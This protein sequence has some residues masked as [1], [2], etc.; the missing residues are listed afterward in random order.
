[1]NC[2]SVW[3]WH[4]ITGKSA[5]SKFKADIAFCFLAAIFFLVSAIIGI[6]VVHRKR[7]TAT[8]NTGRRR[9]YR[10]SRV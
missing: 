3:D 6:W 7:E 10:S 9:W 5:C 4:G 2:G 1:M 8:T